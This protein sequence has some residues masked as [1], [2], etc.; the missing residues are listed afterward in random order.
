MGCLFVKKLNGVYK[1]IGR[2]LQNREPRMI[3]A[4]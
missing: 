1:G 4:P 3:V 2:T